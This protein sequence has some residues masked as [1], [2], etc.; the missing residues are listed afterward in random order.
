MIKL[1]ETYERMFGPLIVEGNKDYYFHSKRNKKLVVMI[2][3]SGSGFVVFPKAAE[4]LPKKKMEDK[5]NKLG[6]EG[7]GTQTLSKQK[8]NVLLKKLRKDKDFY[9]DNS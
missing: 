3:D 2:R 8:G 6:V 5:F 1:K 4:I 7:A 9:E